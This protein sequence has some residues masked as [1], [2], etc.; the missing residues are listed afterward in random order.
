[1]SKSPMDRY[2]IASKMR[3]RSR[4]KQSEHVEINFRIQYETAT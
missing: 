2:N 3:A 1:M 4:K